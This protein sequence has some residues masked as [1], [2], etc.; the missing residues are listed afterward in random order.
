MYDD[1]GVL[2]FGDV[3]TA[4]LQRARHVG[5]PVGAVEQRHRAEALEVTKRY[6]T[7]LCP[8]SKQTDHLKELKVC[9]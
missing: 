9:D 3:Y 2:R 1:D 7:F 4:H 5:L 6:V 8:E